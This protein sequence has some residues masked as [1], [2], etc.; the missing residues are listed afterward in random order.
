MDNLVLNDNKNENGSLGLAR[1]FEELDNNLKNLNI[2]SYSASMRTLEDVFLY[3]A[4]EDTKL[5][6]Q[7]MEKQHRKFS[8]P[9]NDNDKI[10]FVEKIIQINLNFI[11]ISKIVSI[12]DF[13][14][15]QEISKDF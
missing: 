11:M 5:E 6:N 2:K 12:L 7:K 13:Y 8:T 4:A 9:D 10:L 1:F 15:H 14:L 3:L